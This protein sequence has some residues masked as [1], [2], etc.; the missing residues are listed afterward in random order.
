MHIDIITKK[1]LRVAKTPDFTYVYRRKLSMNRPAIPH[2]GNAAT[3][4]MTSRHLRQRFS[5]FVTLWTLQK[6]QARVADPT[7]QGALASTFRTP[8]WARTCLIKMRTQTTWILLNAKL[9]AQ[10]LKVIVH[11]ESTSASKIKQSPK[12]FTS[13]MFIIQCS[14]QWEGCACFALQSLS[15]ALEVFLKMICAI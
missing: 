3:V 8:G 14:V 10:H 4:T 6:F 1:F 5:T 15:S 12:I 2:I 9:P 13:S 11:S 7:V